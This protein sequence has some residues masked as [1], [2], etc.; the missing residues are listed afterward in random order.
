MRTLITGG[1]GFVGAHLAAHLAECGDDVTLSDIEHD[2]ADVAEMTQVL[3]EVQ[4][5]AIYHLAAISHVGNSWDDPSSVL[6]VNV[7]GT[8]AV[9]AAA[10]RVVSTATTLLISS[11][12]VYGAFT[13]DD[14]P[15]TETS[16]VQPIS[17][18][19]A[20]KLAAEVVALQAF[21]GYGQRV[22]IA[23]SFNHFGPGQS[24]SFFVPAIAA[25]LLEASAEGR[26]EVVVGNLTTRRDFT[27]VR[28]V[29]RAYRMIVSGADSGEIYNV[30]SGVD[31]SMQEI[32]DALRDAI[33]PSIGFVP[34]AS[35]MRPADIEVLRGDATKVRTATGW[36]PSY[37]FADTLIDVVNALR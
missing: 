15:L 17:P 1:R 24:T 5:E 13:S 20:S 23:R 33:D 11:A 4:P 26:H 18:Y 12:E 28:D 2:V 27:D 37:S 30:S 10:R 3:D 22:V 32:A 6:R 25:R 34:D 16:P 8:A 19:G 14:L 7:L 29:V 9:L 35:L 21:R 36:S 31:R